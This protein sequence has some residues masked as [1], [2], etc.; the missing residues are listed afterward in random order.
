[1]ENVENGLV[2]TDVTRTDLS[3]WSGAP[4]EHCQAKVESMAVGVDRVVPDFMDYALR[5]YDLLSE[6]Y[7]FDILNYGPASAPLSLFHLT[8]LMQ[9]SPVFQNMLQFFEGVAYDAVEFRITTSNPKGLVGGFVA[10]IYPFQPW[11][12]QGFSGEAAKHDLNNMTRQRLMLSPQSELITYGAAEDIVFDVPWQ[13][14]VPYLPRSYINSQD[15]S[16]GN[17]NLWPGVPVLYFVSLSAYYVSTQSLPAQ[18][19]VFV[20]FNNLRFTAPA[21]LAPSL[22]DGGR[23]VGRGRGFVAQSGVEALVPL[24]A[25]GVE[26]A[27]SRVGDEVLS[28]FSGGGSGVSDSASPA[29]KSTYEDPDAVQLAYIGDSTKIGPPPTTPI[30]R[31][32]VKSKAPAKTAFEMMQEPQFLTTIASGVDDTFYANPTAPRSV[33]DINGSDQNCSYLR[34]F[35]QFA[36]FWRGT[37]IFDFVIMGHAFVETSYNLKIS[38][39]PNSTNLTT[40]YSEN[41]ILKGVCSGIYHI[42][43]PMPFM[44][45]FDHMPIIDAHGM[46]TAQLLAVT[47]SILAWRFDVV[48][49]ALDVTPILYTAVFYRA[50]PDFEFLQPMAVGLGYVENN[51]LLKKRRRKQQLAKQDDS[52]S[53]PEAQCGLPEVAEVFQTRAKAQKP[54]QSM[55]VVNDF[56]AIMSIWSRSLPYDSYDSSDEPIIDIHDATDP[57]W[58]PMNDSAASYTLDVNNSWWVTN[59][60]VSMLSSMFL[61][62]KGSI[63]LKVLC[64][65]QGGVGYRYLALKNAF[66]LRQQGHNPFTSALTGQMPPVSNFGFGCVVTDNQVQPVMEITIPLRSVFE[67]SFTNPQVC[68]SFYTGALD[69]DGYYGEISS[70]IVLHNAS[71]DLIDIL[72]RKAGPD[73]MLAVRSLLPPPTLWVAKGYNWS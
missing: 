11:N 65:T 39:P 24:A 8:K 15:D 30:F 36:Q 60:Y 6:G 61:Y 12:D 66:D 37:I 71:E 58:Y 28:L 62:F 49:T 40:V 34:W 48:S 19:R 63:G 43:V 57:Y 23:R 31:K 67:W 56:S 52:L 38:Y 72:F 3:D 26:M 4:V 14:N 42:Q 22:K 45:P 32:W 9:K 10:G 55:F 64:V 53:D 46:S 69:V 51:S 25:A 5:G 1:M 44:T 2:V 29:N 59:D 73:F 47:P 35:S 33:S 27:V 50:G 41:S 70:N 17:N 18:I 68:S 54:T 16:L 21:V 7:G 13:H 20:K